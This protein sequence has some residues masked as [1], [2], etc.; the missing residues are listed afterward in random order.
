ML[1]RLDLLLK[2]LVVPRP[3][4]LDSPPRFLLFTGK[5]GVGKT[6]VA[7]AAAL[8]LVRQGK[9]VLL[10]S[11]DPASNIGHVFQVGVGD[12]ITPVPGVDR[13]DL[14]EIDPKE[15]AQN[16]RERI[17]APIA[18]LLP[19][20][21]LEAIVEQLSGACTTEIASF[22]EFTSLLADPEATIDYDH[23]VFDTAPTGHTIRLLSLPGDWTRFLDDGKGDASC[24]G[25]MSGLEKHRAAYRGALEALA[26]PRSAR[27][28]LVA[29]PQT[30]A[31]EEADRTYSE[32]TALG[33]VPT[34]LVVNACLPD[35]DV[36]DD[37]HS[38]LKRRQGALLESLQP[39]L[40]SL[41]CDEIQMRPWNMV[42]I[43][44]LDTVFKDESG[45]R[46]AAQVDEL[47]APLPSRP[48]GA[49]VDELESAGRGL[50]MTVGKGGVGKTTIAAAIAQ[51]LHKR[52]HRVHLTTTDPAA[53]VEGALGPTGEGLIVDSVDPR[54]AS[55]EYRRRVMETKGA[56]LDDDGRAALAEDLRSPCTEEIAVFSRFSKIVAEAETSFVVMDTAPTGHTL[57][58]M[59]ATGS[60]HREAVRHMAQGDSVR[61]VTPLTRLQDAEYTKILVVTLAE[62][63]PV[64]EASE[65]SN[66]L[67]RAGIHEWA[68]VINQSLAAAD[69]ASHLLR[70][71]AHGEYEQIA[72]V[73]A[74]A[75]RL[76]L[77][78][79]RADEPKG[80]DM[81]SDLL[82][83]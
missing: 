43:D 54:S 14:L 59:D 61:E 30:S 40:A 9:R 68:W 24:L 16:Y 55:E 76:A 13:L 69:P 45:P 83:A 3:R 46:D 35:S 48:L 33:I 73:E 82:R 17:L 5:G 72:E 81:L 42:G 12:A 27:I 29:R 20:R 26:D 57:L 64:I 32:L 63:T 58:L 62:T 38:A 70:A 6:S 37:L 31:L 1:L 2:D 10:V 8:A 49:L 66:D 65:L 19:A 7:S 34:H 18:P 53:H 11:T 78:A 51:A 77:I 79:V 44:A 41:E 74:R 4:L 60:Y 15:T 50:I 56:E 71:R 28:V 39:P 21:E 75:Q 67:A 23:V 47:S 36:A 22:N 80:E 52:G 25:P